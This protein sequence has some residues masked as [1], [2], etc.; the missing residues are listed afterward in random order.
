MAR[1]VRADELG[2]AQRPAVSLLALHFLPARLRGDVPA[3]VR[4]CPGG[5]ED[6]VFLVALLFALSCHFCSPSM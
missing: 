4:G 3:L 2:I 6:R 1:Q 5:G